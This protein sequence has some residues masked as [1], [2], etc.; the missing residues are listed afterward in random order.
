MAS[1]KTRGGEK[2]MER[3]MVRGYIAGAMIGIVA[4][5]VVLGAYWNQ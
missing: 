3:Y 1:K 4:L 5:V 2:L